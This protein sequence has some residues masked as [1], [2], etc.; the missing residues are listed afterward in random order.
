MALCG[1]AI[2]QKSLAKI[3][4]CSITT[5]NKP[6]RHSTWIKNLKNANFKV[7]LLENVR[8]CPCTKLAD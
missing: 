1:I 5:D 7:K 8:G 2:P 6:V 4:L 3:T